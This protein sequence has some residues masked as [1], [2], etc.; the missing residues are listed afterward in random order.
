MP[1]A[2]VRQLRAHRDEVGGLG[3]LAVGRVARDDV[4]R[5]AGRREGAGV[6]GDRPSPGVRLLD[7]GAERAEARGL[8]RLRGHDLVA[9]DRCDHPLAADALQGV[10]D[11]DD[12]HDGTA[13]PRGPP[14][15]DGRDQLRRDRRA[16]RVVDEDERLVS[17]AGAG[18]RPQARDH[19]VGSR[20]AAG[21]DEAATL[22][23][24]GAHR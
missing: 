12:R 24:A 4:D 21:N 16:G 22:A 1:V 11:R 9:L 3:Q 14:R 18:Q 6:I 20:V 13:P 17:V 2:A 8:R 10:D 15:H 19:R 23:G 7:R 5:H